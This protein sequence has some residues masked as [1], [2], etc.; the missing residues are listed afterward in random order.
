MLKPFIRY[1]VLLMLAAC[2]NNETGNGPQNISDNTAC[3]LDGM[4]LADFPGPKAQI[5]YANGHEP[6]YFCDTVEMMSVYLQPEQQS[7]VKAI[8]TQDMGQADW[9]K[10]QG[11]WIDARS[12]YFVV[13]ST[14]EGSM[15]K[16][17]A[18]FAQEKDA[19][20]FAAQFGGKVLRFGDINADMADLHG[21]A[22]H[23]H[24]M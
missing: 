22:L 13:D 7:K 15:G 12:A 14:R 24:S 6:D 11:H 4:I 2:Q 18:T 5:H 9:D 19:T 17:Y 3:S 23:D 8:Y 21:G 1:G 10:P 20:A 16:T